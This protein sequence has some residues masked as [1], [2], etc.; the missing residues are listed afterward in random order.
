[1]SLQNLKKNKRPFTLLEVMV[2]LVLLVIAG[3]G[4]VWKMQGAIQKKRFQSELERFRA[5]LTVCQRLSVA[6]QSDWKGV[7]ERKGNEWVFEVSCEEEARKLPPLT[8]HSKILL[9]GKKFDG[10]TFDFFS[11]GE[12]FPLATLT[13][14]QKDERTEWQLSEIFEREEGKKL[15]PLHPADQ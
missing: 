8:L 15:G 10:M 2:A 1:M 11:S 5:R 14:S 3:G 4:I 6:M 13:F 12:V 7:L 9:N